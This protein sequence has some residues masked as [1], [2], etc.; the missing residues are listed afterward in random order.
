MQIRLVSY[1]IRKARGSDGR[2]HPG[3]ILDILNRLGGDIV[4]LQ[5][6]DLRLGPRPTALPFRMIA[7]E[8][9]YVPA[10]VAASEVS[11]GWHGNA[12]LLRKGLKADWVERV[13][14][15]A[16]EP[17]GAVLAG[18]ATPLGEIAVMG[19]HLALIRRW[20][21]LQ[22]QRIGERLAGDLAARSVV[23]G[24]LNEWSLS[25]GLAGLC[26]HHA[27]I[28]PGRSFPAR[29]PLGAL[30]RFAVGRGLRVTGSGVETS[31]P[32]RKGSDHLP[33]WIDLA[34]V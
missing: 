30:D 18:V 9:D 8:T 28:S 26:A 11:L 16:L 14:L 32:A 27:L 24:D 34:A 25:K 6:A 4:I 10:P 13:E 3:R 15:P 5:E 19:A 23:A 20:R 17:R 21:R 22:A 12:I 7:A 31:A 2:R 29:R 33:V 1:N